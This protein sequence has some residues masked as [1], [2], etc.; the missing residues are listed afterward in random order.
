MTEA[1]LT[2]LNIELTTDPMFLG[3]A[4]KTDPEMAELINTMGLSDETIGNTDVLSSEIRNALD[5]NEYDA[6]PASRREFVWNVLGDPDRVI[7]ITIVELRDQMLDTFP[8]VGFPNTRAALQELATRT[9]TRAEALFDEA[10]A[11]ISFQ[12]IAEALGR[13]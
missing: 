8:L 9:A 4:G 12:D 10:G 2:L 7:D 13:R 6:L 11:S 5:L 1:E 3:Y